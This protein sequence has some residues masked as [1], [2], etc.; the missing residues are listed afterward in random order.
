[1]GLAGEDYASIALGIVL[2]LLIIGIVVAVL[3]KNGYIGRKVS[4]S[5]EIVDD[6][7]KLFS[8]FS[9]SG[10]SLYSES[11]GPIDHSTPRSE[12]KP[13]PEANPII[14]LYDDIYY[15]PNTQPPPGRSAKREKSSRRKKRRKVK[16]EILP[17][18][19]ENKPSPAENET[20]VTKT[21]DNKDE[22]IVVIPDTGINMYTR[23]GFQDPY[24]DW[25]SEFIPHH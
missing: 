5:T 22:D 20:P 19:S 17:K 24:D 16:Q 8:N 15:P 6:K 12:Y 14:Y 1:M 9:R 21:D 11:I 13:G 3:V 7:P 23:Y 18:M 2:F 4:P 25:G 10:A